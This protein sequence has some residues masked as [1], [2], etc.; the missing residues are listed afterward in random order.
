MATIARHSEGASSLPLETEQNRLAFSLLTVPYFSRKIAEIE[1][2]CISQ[3]Q[4][5]L[6][7]LPPG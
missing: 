2:L 1:R 4:L 7:P 6:A 3:F 5:H